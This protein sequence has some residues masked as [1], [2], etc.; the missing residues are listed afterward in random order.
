MG[1]QP[2]AQGQRYRW[3]VVKKILQLATTCADQV[4]AYVGTLQWKIQSRAECNCLLGNTDFRLFGQ[5]SEI[6][7][8]GA[9]TIP[10]VKIHRGIDIGGISSQDFLN[11]G[12]TLEKTFPVVNG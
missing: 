4:I 9:V 7:D 12:D 11:D 3:T 1:Q 2:P 5:A 10:C 8:G 6:L